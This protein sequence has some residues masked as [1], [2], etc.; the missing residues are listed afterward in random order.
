[1]ASSAVTGCLLTSVTRP[2]GLSTLTTMNPATAES[3]SST[4]SML[5]SLKFRINFPPGAV[6]TWPLA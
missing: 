3:S 4:E 1:M 6:V 2:S 5:A